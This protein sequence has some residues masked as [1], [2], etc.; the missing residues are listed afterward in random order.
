MAETMMRIPIDFFDKIEFDKIRSI[1]AEQCKGSN[2][3]AYFENLDFLKDVEEIRYNLLTAKEFHRSFEFPERIPVSSYHDIER[4]LFL[5]SK[6]NYI[7]DAEAL[8]RIN[9]TI[10][11][12]HDLITFFKKSTEYTLLQQIALQKTFEPSLVTMIN[13]VLDEEGNVRPDASPELLKISKRIQGKMRE[14]DSEFA[15]IVKYYKE[16]NMVN[17]SPESY[18]NGRRVLALPAELKR[19]VNGVIHDESATGKTVFMEPQAMVKLNNDL[20]AFEN[21]YRVEINRIFKALCA[22]LRKHLHVIEGYQDLIIEM[23]IIGSKGRWA[24]MVD[25]QFPEI[26]DQPALHFKEAYHPLLKLK[27]DTEEKVTVPFDLELQGSNRIVLVSG[28]NAG[29]K[30]ILMKSV[31]LLQ[32]MLQCGIPITVNSDSK[33]GYFKRFM[34]DIGDQQSIENDLSTYSSRLKIMS[35]ALQVVDKDTLLVIDEFGS[36]TDPKFGGALA[37]SMLYAFNKKQCYGVVTTHYSNL[38][39]FAFKTKGIVNAAMIFDQE[40]LLP[41][42]QMRIGKPGSSFAF[43]IADKS[44]IPPIVM[45][46]ARIK[47]GEKETKV[48]DLLIQLE[49]EKK[50]T[51]AKLEK[52]LNKEESL[53]RLINT[54]ERLHKDL[55]YRRKKLKLEIKEQQLIDSADQNKAFENLI[56]ELKEEKKIEVAKKKAADLKA[57]RERLHIERNSIDSAI[58]DHLHFDV[59]DLKVGDFVKVGNGDQIGT[60]NWIKKGKAEINFGNLTMI[61]KVNTLVPA[62]EPIVK[63]KKSVTSELLNSNQTLTEIDLRGMSKL[64]ADRM[65]E[66]FLDKALL[67]NASRLKIIHGVGSGILRKAVLKKVREYP[68]IKQYFHPEMEYGGD[69]VTLIDI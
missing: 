67:S 56:R 68:D 69:G 1:L 63:K 44:G 15:Q 26:Q 28:P 46:Y 59:A 5:L 18:R 14:I 58:Q 61:A 21:D 4:D 41:T 25:A 6:N 36:G 23:D 34:A 54:Y 9:A 45:K 2:G 13:K 29:G 30:S 49:R 11:Q 7:L 16:R 52:L 37:E 39:S 32:T 55:E 48:E 65:L 38:K 40:K 35:E 10:R 42:Y 19:Q 24:R 50:E 31:I 3:K 51:E 62:K 8:F 20:V 27:N 33:P 66:E 60:I 53:D 57:K 17:T 43:E 47:T 64:D 22:D 12:G